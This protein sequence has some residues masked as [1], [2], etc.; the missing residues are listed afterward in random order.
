M[1]YL[2]SL[3][4]SLL[5]TS[6][7]AQWMFIVTMGVSAG[8]FALAL[9]LIAMFVA[10]PVRR[11][12]RGMAHHESLKG[13]GNVFVDA[14]EPLGVLVRPRR[15]WEKNRILREL[16]EAG[17]RTENAYSAFLAVKGLLILALPAAVFAG[18]TLYPN[19]T[20]YQV[21]ALVLVA[22]FLG[23]VL[24][25][26]FLA[27]AV[28][29]RKRK[30]MNAFPDALDLLVSSSEAGLGLNAALE[31]V[32]DEMRV[33]HPELGDELSL[34]NAEIRAGVERIEAL[35][36]L[37][38]RTGIDDIK[39]LVSLLS[40]SLRFGSS[41]ADALRIY[42]EEFRDKRMQ[43]A[44]EQAAKIGTK[45]IFPLIFCLFPAFFLVAVGP[46]ILGVIRVLQAQ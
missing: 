3:F 28:Q 9:V 44:E 30:I 46:A 23:G 7:G 15:E 13:G 1:E 18:A 41:V 19:F 16:V 39:G 21:G 8:A 24:P 35:R 22:A 11:R 36:N 42:A 2:V 34:V 29:R 12:L 37:A 6:S 17:Y 4:S 43:R 31:R 5:G 38:V 45:L 40:Q 32:A 33:S 26:S 10:D 25:N 27:N 14:I 20:N